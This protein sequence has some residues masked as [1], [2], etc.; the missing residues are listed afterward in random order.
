VLEHQ[1]IIFAQ[2]KIKI[3]IHFSLSLLD[4]D[5]NSTRLDS[6]PRFY[7]SFD[8]SFCPNKFSLQLGALD[9]EILATKAMATRASRPTPSPIASELLVLLLVLPSVVT[10]HAKRRAFSMSKSHRGVKY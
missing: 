8:A 2:I 5:V 9:M 7:N 3:I 1:S 4:L 6:I 10:G